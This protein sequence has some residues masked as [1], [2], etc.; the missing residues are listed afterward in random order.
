[1]S[2]I[3]YRRDIDGLRA[4][5]VLFVIVFHAFPK[6]V[7]GGF[8]GVDIFFVISGYLITGII[9]RELASNTF[10]IA[11]FYLRR[12]RRIFPALL[13]V[14]LFTVSLGWFFFL[15]NELI[16]LGRNVYA[17]ALFAPNLMLLSEVGYFDTAAQLKPLLHLWSLGIEEQFYAA[18]PPFLVFI[19]RRKSNLPLSIAGLAIGS[20]VLNLV[21]VKSNPAATFYLPVTR[22]WELLV[23]SFLAVPQI[24]KALQPRA[25][26]DA[27][28]RATFGV[29]LIGIG[30]AMLNQ[31][32]P[33]PGW[34]AL[35]PVIGTALLIVAQTASFNQTVLSSTVLVFI[36]LI[37][38]PIYLWHWPLLSFVDI[39]FDNPTTPIVRSTII[40]LSIVF[41]YITFRYIEIPLRTGGFRLIKV[42]GLS[43]AMILLC[44]SGII[45]VGEAGFPSRLSTAIR[46]AGLLEPNLSSL[47]QNNCL[48]DSS[49]QAAFA[50]DCLDA[51]SSPVIMLWGDSTAAALM[52]GF[53]Q[54][55][56]MH[57]F[58]LA[59]FTIQSCW[60]I[61]DTDIPGV[62]K[63]REMNDKVLSIV[64]R[65]KPEI[66]VLQGIWS[67]NFEELGKTVSR[68]KELSV[69]RVIVLGRVPVWNA[70]LPTSYLKYFLLYHKVPP[71]RWDRS[72]VDSDWTD[73]VIKRYV[74]SAGGEFISINADL[75]ND[76]GCL[77]RAGDSS[78]DIIVRDRLHFTEA[79]A[80]FLM[81]KIQA[82]IFQSSISRY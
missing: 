45:I 39:L 46:E 77:T 38:Y 66:I 63:C 51:G 34:G 75:C 27:N 17:G 33:Y 72:R 26:L 68:L 23:G 82:Q 64:Q 36:G 59:Q 80:I 47:R 9:L 14:L 16:S 43:T 8:S 61:L 30:A 67:A 60:P 40:I 19:A 20:F 12:I 78:R 13:T 71:A 32:M 21:F 79:G 11:N 35:L 29:I 69:P 48:L 2:E 62:P 73:A 53:R 74:E 4:I 52:P 3:G 28:I 1:M 31:R 44:F 70:D 7:P 18:L 56:Q 50:D 42:A 6:I 5:A 41:A 76:I 49:S 58:R 37:S 55:Q 54:L 15:P 81:D 25:E 24:S 22:A 65:I 57:R 10:S